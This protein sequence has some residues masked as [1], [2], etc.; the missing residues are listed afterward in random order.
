[1][2]QVGTRFHIVLEGR[3]VGYGLIEAIDGEPPNL[4]HHEPCTQGTAIVRRIGVYP[5]SRGCIIARKFI[6][7]ARYIS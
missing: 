7:F 4:C 2:C 3:T 5:G 6:V 1:M